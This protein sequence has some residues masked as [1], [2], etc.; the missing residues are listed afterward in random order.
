LLVKTTTTIER[1]KNRPGFDNWMTGRYDSQNHFVM[2]RPATPNPAQSH[3]HGL[4]MWGIIFLTN[5]LNSTTMHSRTIQCNLGILL[6][7]LKQAE[8]DEKDYFHFN[9]YLFIRQCW[10]G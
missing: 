9:R 7:N 6:I 2:D 3:Q 1:A 4:L 8:K 10:Y 5:E